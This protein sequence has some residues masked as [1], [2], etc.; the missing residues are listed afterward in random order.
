MLIKIN[1]V[2]ANFNNTGPYSRQLR[3]FKMFFGNDIVVQTVQICNRGP[4]FGFNIAR[5]IADSIFL[6]ARKLELHCTSQ[7]LNEV[8]D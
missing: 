7:I 5:C 8:Q 1:T 3:F 2:S 4:P 6:V